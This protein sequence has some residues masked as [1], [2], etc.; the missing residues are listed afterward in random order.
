MSHLVC[1]YGAYK[2]RHLRNTTICEIRQELVTGMTT[3][4][5]ANNAKLTE[6]LAMILAR[7]HNRTP[8]HY[9]LIHM[10]DANISC[11]IETAHMLALGFF[12][13]S[14]DIRGCCHPN[15]KLGITFVFAITTSLQY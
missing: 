3:P 10:V 13:G 6:N 11:Y 9:M 7:L 4:G 14:Q 5:I 1:D 8:V 12:T 2:S 15:H